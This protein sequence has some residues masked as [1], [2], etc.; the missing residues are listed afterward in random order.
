MI[1]NGY[2]S[3]QRR[4]SVKIS[5]SNHTVFADLSQKSTFLFVSDLHGCDNEPIF[6]II[7]NTPHDAILV[8]GDLVHDEK[9][10]K[11]GIEFLNKV[12]PNGNC[13]VVLGNHESCF[14]GNIRK[15]ICASGATLLDNSYVEF[16]DI[17]LGGLTSGEFYKPMYPNTA[18]LK[19]FSG[20][21]GFKVLLC[22]RPEYYAKYIKKL[23]IDLTLCGHAHGGQWRIF[24][25]GIY[26]PGQGIFPK[27]TSGIY[28]NRLIV[29]RG[30]GNPHV[31]PRINN[32]PEILVIN[33]LPKQ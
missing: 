18:W 6:D 33:V 7:N 5:L 25:R 19:E 20:L 11:K 23:P 3:L 1:Y 2:I 10:Y 28:E 9:N 24:D 21:D 13:F 4:G 30:L 26:A 8:G 16:G 32:S 29:S 22:H 12:S 31:I 15:E 14:P 27:Y 17:K